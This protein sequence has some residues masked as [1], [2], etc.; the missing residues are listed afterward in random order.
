M[1]QGQTVNQQ[2]YREVL[3]LLRK[4]VHFVRPEIADTWMLHHHNAPC[5]T[6]NSVNECLTKKGTP[7]VPQ[8]PYSSDLSPFDFFL[9]PKLEF[10]LQ[11]RHFGTVDNIQKVMTDQL[12]ALPH[13]DFQHCYREREQCLQL[14]VVS[15]GNYFEVD[16]VD[17]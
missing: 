16:N 7:A 8:P 11:G 13:E 15:L 6:A 4:R 14:C 3:E 1:P 9:F 12:R 10:H 5:H 17:L 2:Y